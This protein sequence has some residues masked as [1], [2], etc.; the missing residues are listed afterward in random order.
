[1]KPNHPYAVSLNTGCHCLRRRAHHT[2]GEVRTRVPR[3]T[4]QVA[5]W[6]YWIFSLWNTFSHTSTLNLATPSG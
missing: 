6:D 3:S 2:A 5:L 4:S 1:M